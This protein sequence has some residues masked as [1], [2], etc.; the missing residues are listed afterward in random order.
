MI[1]IYCFGNENWT[2][3]SVSTDFVPDFVLSLFHHPRSHT[4]GIGLVSFSL[5]F[6]YHKNITY[7]Y[8]NN[9]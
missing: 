9:T 7:K 1:G 3:Y 6:I 4:C 8:L 5:N 2:P